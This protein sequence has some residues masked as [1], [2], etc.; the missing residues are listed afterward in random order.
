MPFESR[1]LPRWLS[2]LL[3]VLLLALQYWMAVDSK[4]NHSTTS[5]ELVHLTAG[6]V[7]WT[8]G[9][10]RLHPENGNL[11][12]RWAALPAWLGGAQPP[13]IDTE[14]WRKSDVWMVGYDFFY[15]RGNDHE[16]WLHLGRAMIALFATAT[17]L[18]IFCWARRLWGEWGGFTALGFYVFCPNLLA[19]GALVT[20]D[21][22]MTFFF[23]ASVGAYW[24]HLHTGSWSAWMISAGVFSV[25]C[26]AKF[27]AALLLPMMGVMAVVRTWHPEPLRLGGRTIAGRPAKLGAIVLSTLGHGVVAVAVIWLFFGFR[28]SAFNPA[29]PAAEQFIRPWEWVRHNIGLQGDVIAALASVR[30]LPEGFLYGYAYTIESVL[31]RAAFLDGEYSIKGWIGFFPK[32]FF[33]KTPIPLLLAIAAG[34]ALTVLKWRSLASPRLSRITG[35]LY[36]V[37]PLLVLFVLYWVFSLTTNLNIGHRHIL[38]TY[39]VLFIF[40]GVLGYAISRA[41]AHRQGGGLALAGVTLGLLAWF[42]A[43]SWRIRPH[44]LAYFSPIAGGPANGYRHLVDSSLDWGQDLPTLQRWLDSHR[45]PGEPLY[46]SYFGT[47]K[48]AHYR[49]GAVLMPTINDFKQPRPW[50]WTEPGLYAVSA[51]ML[52]QVYSPIRG[53]W[54][55]EN[56]A[57]YQALRK[58]DPQ[59]RA[60][61][62]S[63]YGHPELMKDTTPF[64]WAGKWNLY[65]VLRFTR[66]CHYLRARQPDA[67]AGYSILIYRLTQAELDAALEGSVDKL[68][69]AIERAAVETPR[70]A[71]NR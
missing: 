26:V 56:E 17:G 48:P 44:Y 42:A 25:A 16:H 67:T 49:L 4:R 5:D 19:H 22:C 40:V 52:Q 46:L 24:R 41:F 3:V 23:L 34:A 61:K 1:L 36:R 31:F 29:L 37:T 68:A 10:Y 58:L 18:L 47:S 63:P 60:L 14:F 64:E 6:Y 54:T 53:P 13:V 38:P 28:Y 15:G 69:A 59:F 8:M 57:Q 32:A 21:I 51:T 12:Q 50:Y 9:D 33:Y 7:Y 65:D 20:S 71:T 70:D 62:A 11:P 45:K 66:L 35:H 43:E 30:I 2:T 55:A 39:P 27:S